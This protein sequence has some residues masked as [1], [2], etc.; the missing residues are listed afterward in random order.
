VSSR[1]VRRHDREVRLERVEQ[2][3]QPLE[4]VAVTPDLDR[5]ALD[6]DEPRRLPPGR[7]RRRAA[8]AAQ[9][10]SMPSRRSATCFNPL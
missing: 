2:A 4:R 8:R 10:A 7:I 3:E 6:L 9:R 5:A 1:P